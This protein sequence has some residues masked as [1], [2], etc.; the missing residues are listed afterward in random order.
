MSPTLVLFLRRSYHYAVYALGGAVIVVCAVALALRFWFLPDIGQYKA[1]LEREASRAVGAPVRIGQLQ[2]DWLGLNPRVSLLGVRVQPKEGAPLILP[3]VDAIASWL[4]LPLFDLRLARL[5]VVAPQLVIRRDRD[6]ILYVGGIPVNQSA[7]PSPFP[8]WLLRQPRVVVK[9]ARIEW[10]DELLDAPPLQFRSV[11][12]LL[13]NRFGRHR[14]GGVALP[15][16][17]LARLELRGDLKGRTVRDP[18]S[19]SGAVYARIDG[20]Q[21]ASWRQWAPWAQQAVKTGSGDMRFW[22]NVERGQV[23]GLEGDARLTDLTVNLEAGLPDIA[24]ASLSG[25]M[26]WERKAQTHAFSVAGLRFRT[27]EGRESEPADVRVSVTPDA[28]GA[29]VRRVDAGAHNLRLEAF[30][31]LTGALP[32]PR[33]AHD[34]IEALGPRGLVAEAEG[35]WAGAQDYAVKMTLADAGMKP[36]GA[37]PGVTGLSGRLV[38]SQNGGLAE[39]DSRKLHLDWDRVFRHTLAFDTVKAEAKWR[40][41]DNGLNVEFDVGRLTNAD[42]SGGVKG[43]VDLPLKGAPKVDIQGRFTRG[44]AAAVYRYLPRSVA[45]DAYL[46][47]RRGLVAGRSDDVR[48]T[49]KGDLGRFPFDKGGGEFLV[50][51]KMQ[52]GVLDYAPRWPRLEGVQGLLEFRGMGMYIAAERARILKAELGPVKAVI[53]DLHYSWDETLLVEGRAR[54]ATQDFL[55]F[56]RASPVN[57]YTG[58]ATEALR[59]E[60]AG[61]LALNLRVPLRHVADSTVSGNFALHGNRITAGDDLPELAEMS[62]LLGFTERGIQS[63]GLRTK[64][65]GLPAAL[66]LVSQPGGQVL[67]RLSGRVGAEQLRPHLPPTLASRVQG[68]TAW[69]AEVGVGAQ[70]NI[71]VTSDL[72]GLALDLPAPLGKPA[73]RAAAFTL[74]KTS[75]EAEGVQAR[76]GDVLHLRAHHPGDPAQRIGV[77]LGAGDAVLPAEA[78]ISVA[79]ALRQLDLDAWRALAPSGQGGAGPAFKADIKA[80]ELRLME[81]RLHDAHLQL[82]PAGSGWRVQLASREIS[83]EVLT[84]PD[85]GGQRIQ[86]NFRRLALGGGEEG[87]AR[88]QADAP[89]DGIASLDLEAERLVWKDKELGRLNLRLR[90]AA[91]G[92]GFE[93]QNLKLAS[94]DGAVQGSGL[95]A[96]RIEQPTRMTLSLDSPDLGK[97]L[98]RLGHPGAIRGGETHAEGVLSWQGGV[99]DFRLE[100]LIGNVSLKIGKGQFLKADPGAARLLGILSL[101]SLPR[102]ITLDFRDIFTDGFAFDE[103]KGD[104]RLSQGVARTTDMNLKGPAARIGMRGSVD[105]VK[106]T[107]DLRLH[108]QPRLEDTVAVAGALLGGPVVG[109]GAFIANKLLKNPIGEAVTFDYDVTGAWA[110]PVVKKIPR[111]LK[112]DKEEAPGAPFL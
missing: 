112:E 74:V 49:L 5:D 3:R 9:D 96:S 63:Q 31:A 71:T 84:Q 37:L 30:T 1:E 24:L 88:P 7:E 62:G 60:G 56:V 54:G 55:E 89:L 41:E 4:S 80:Q 83:G 40:R 69:R 92:K 58:R 20:A 17:A 94:A 97:L 6:G 101:Q 22:L 29:G 78:G 21:F 53:P 32:L 108:I 111:V 64:V 72:A 106:E 66:E 39:L 26:G 52:D 50:S 34:L 46:W 85:A 44:Q 87:P 67:A 107:Q 15:D 90:R 109:L 10:R 19:W 18:P 23:A 28:A 12:L 70:R 14:F 75:G 61:D 86:A 38:A 27:P 2:A 42:I 110:E 100:D 65:L 48:L 8:D 68:A 95:M 99:E 51:V 11:R 47:L 102:R 105:L 43:R 93:V 13:K 104:L 77:R 33:K 82:A 103:I 81:R 79:G 98:T 57:E 36:W 91:A 76:Y 73:D 45:D 59:A 25:R 16:D 35:H